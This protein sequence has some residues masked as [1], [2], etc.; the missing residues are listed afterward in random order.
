MSI[1]LKAGNVTVF[2]T[3]PNDILEIMSDDD[4]ISLIESLSCYDAIVKHVSDQ[5]VYSS[6]ENGNFGSMNCHWDKEN[7]T[8]LDKIRN[9]IAKSSSELS[10]KRIEYLDKECERLN[11]KYQ[12][13]LNNQY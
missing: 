6:T 11:N 8:P 10:K 7:G 12:K 3:G 9:V 1:E 13:L 2:L 5:L 4:K